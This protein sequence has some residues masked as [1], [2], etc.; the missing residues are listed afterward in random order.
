MRFRKVSLVLACT[1][2][3]ALSLG[4]CAASPEAASS[5]QASANSEANKVFCLVEKTNSQDVRAVALGK[6]MDDTLAKPENKQ[7]T[8][9]QN[10]GV[11]KTTEIEGQLRA[12]K[13]KNVL[14]LE[15]GFAEELV[16]IAKNN[17]E[18][19][20]AI[21]GAVGKT[22]SL[23]NANGIDFDLRQPA[24][25]AGYAAAGVTKSG[26]VGAVSDLTPADTPG[27]PEVNPGIDSAISWANAFRLGVEYY[28]QFKGSGVT[29]AAWDQSAGGP[30]RVDSAQLRDQ[31]LKLADEK[32][33]VLFVMASPGES[34]VIEGLATK[35]AAAIWNGQDL[36]A[37]SAQLQGNVLTSTVI[38]ASGCVKQLM[39]QL[40][41]GSITGKDYLGTLKNSGVKLAGWGDYAPRFSDSL[42]AELAGIRSQI[43]SGKIDITKLAAHRG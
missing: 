35:E 21:M 26:K 24:F 5:R 33:D 36:A 6:A 41:T 18:I 31:L 40:Q 39:K 22:E 12:K 11:E 38:D 28:N 13:C 17:A 10:L 9:I 19:N 32:V 7:L 25:L 4:A 3:L 30:L 42:T 29:L 34:A 15:P 16:A 37:T 23:G 43:D 1:A 27:K 2:T 14:S 8:K 20:F